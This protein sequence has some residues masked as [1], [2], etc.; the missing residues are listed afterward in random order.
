[1]FRE[2]GPGPLEMESSENQENEAEKRSK[3]E[4]LKDLNIPPVGKGET[5]LVLL[6][7]KPA[8]ELRI[9]SSGQEKEETIQA[10]ANLGLAVEVTEEIEEKNLIKIAI[11]LSQKNVDKLKSLDP[12][13]DHGEY[14]KLMGFP[15]TAVNAFGKPE[16]TLPYEKSR[17]L[18]RDL[19]L[20]K[21]AF[22]Q[23]HCKEE[24]EVMKKWN[25]AIL[26]YAPWIFDEV[27]APEDA[28]R[29]KNKLNSL[30]EQE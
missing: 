10:L 7:L 5:V 14:G 1:M 23:E 21:F 4:K 12:D 15:E 2:S 25:L 3:I 27:Y 26:E 16:A 11:S 24:L 22:S 9:S 28:E 6:G 30:R 19:P 13:K 8:T 17:K 20:F 18:T 29:I